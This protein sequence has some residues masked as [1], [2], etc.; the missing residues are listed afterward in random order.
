[1]DTNLYNELDIIYY[2]NSIDMIKE[3][4]KIN[5]AIFGPKMEEFLAISEAEIS[6]YES[7]II[8]SILNFFKK[9]FEK[10]VD[11]FTKIINF[12]S[13]KTKFMP[14]KKLI[15]AV[16][17]KF[18]STSREEKDSHV[19]S[20]AE[21]CNKNQLPYRDYLHSEIISNIRNLEIIMD[22]IKDLFYK[23]LSET[24]EEKMIKYA[25][26]IDADEYNSVIEDP[27][28][29][30][31]KLMHDG[32]REILKEYSNTPS[33]IQKDRLDIQSYKIDMNNY[34][35][36]IEKA[37][38]DNKDNKLSNVLQNYKK[39]STAC[40]NSIT[41]G[42]KKLIQEELFVFKSNERLLK[43]Y[44]QNDKSS[45][46]QDDFEWDNEFDEDKWYEDF[47]KA[48]KSESDNE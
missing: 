37:L 34:R 18:K 21:H 6:I 11:F 36:L 9:L 5:E 43:R 25:K 17:N 24:E 12:I 40:C 14:N 33:T 30:N 45:E 26:E 10:V 38:R 22:N 13:D 2:E 48:F 39:V 47:N 27:L 16:E 46:G 1:M 44:L 20:K 19:Y 15:A 29:K 23:D 35:K 4:R 42:C 41:Y 3:N 28:T 31:Y 8:Q 32:I 7:K